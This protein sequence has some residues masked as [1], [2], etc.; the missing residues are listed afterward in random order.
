M[1]DQQQAQEYWSG[2]PLPSPADLLDPGIKLGSAALQADFL[3]TE[4][5]GKE[6]TEVLGN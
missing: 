2:Y 3:P 4:L 1:S 6:K 5:S